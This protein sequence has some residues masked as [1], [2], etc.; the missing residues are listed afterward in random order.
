MFC[1]S[2]SNVDNKNLKFDNKNSKFDSQEVDSL[3]A[4]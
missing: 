3:K 1:L 4:S 2:N